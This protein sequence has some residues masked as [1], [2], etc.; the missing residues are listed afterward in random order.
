MVALGIGEHH[1]AGSV[2]V[3]TIG[4]LGAAQRDHPIDLV[5]PTP[6]CGDEVA[7]LVGIVRNGDVAK[8]PF[9]HSD[10]SKASRQSTVV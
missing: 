3:A 2:A 8:D 1:P 6:I 9:H 10:N 7:G 4:D 5:V